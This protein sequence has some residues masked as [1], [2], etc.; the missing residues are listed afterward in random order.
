MPRTA[1]KDIPPLKRLQRVP[2]RLVAGVKAMAVR[3]QQA[4]LN[5][6]FNTPRSP[7]LLVLHGIVHLDP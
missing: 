1:Y 2:T 3:R 6:V 7:R 5:A 4:N